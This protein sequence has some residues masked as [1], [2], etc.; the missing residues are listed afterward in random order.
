MV[1]DSVV[2]GGGMV[3]GGGGAVVVGAGVV[4]GGGVVGR[5][6]RR[7]RGGCGRRARGGNEEHV[8]VVRG[9]LPGPRRI[10]GLAAIGVHAGAGLQ[11]A[12][13]EH[14][15]AE[16]VRVG[17]VPAGRRVV[18]HHVPPAALQRHRA[19]KPRRLPAGRGL[20]VERDTGEQA[21]PVVPEASGVPAGVV[22]VLVEPDAG[23]RSGLTGAEGRPELD[24]AGVRVRRLRGPH[25]RR[26]QRHRRR[27]RAGVAAR[28]RGDLVGHQTGRHHS[29][30]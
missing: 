6:R 19:G 20:V 27:G 25:V 5:R 9:I 13:G 8:R 14:P 18:R 3:V 2:I 30:E 26:P 11:H 12:A 10:P 24:R 4:V 22:R 7:R 28:C 1:G 23:D 29:D 15:V 17:G 21:T 16:V